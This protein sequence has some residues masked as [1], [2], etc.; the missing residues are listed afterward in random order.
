MPE[1]NL[2]LTEDAFIEE[3][4]TLN[5]GI[6]R[7]VRFQFPENPR[8]IEYDRRQSPYF[9]LE[10]TLQLKK[11][12]TAIMASHENPLPTPSAGSIAFFYDSNGKIDSVALSQ[13]DLNAP[14]DPGF[15][16]LRNGFPST[17]QEWFNM[18]HIYREAFEEGIFVTKSGSELVFPEDQRYDNY[19]NEAAERM[20]SR[21]N[22]KINGTRRVPIVFMG[23]ND[24]FYLYSEGKRVLEKTGTLI[25]TPEIGF[26]FIQPMEI[27]YPLSELNL[28]DA[29]TFPDGSPICRDVCEIRLEE[30]KGKS[31]GDNIRET[32]HSYKEGRFYSNERNARFLTDKCVRAVL[33]QTHADGEPVY[34]KDWME[35]S[36]EFLNNPRVTAVYDRFSWSDIENKLIL[37]N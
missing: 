7:I 5:D 14:R 35:E 31:F 25:W 1:I 30:L 6:R 32:V 4:P 33:N 24:R 8:V 13:K 15:R 3:E 17:R 16:V 22:L 36:Y 28:V 21:T 9:W 23:G 26:N 34:P 37:G 29:E 27:H 19:I 20:V 11:Y 18:E 12:G 2:A 10:K